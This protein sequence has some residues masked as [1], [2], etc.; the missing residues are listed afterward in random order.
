MVKINVSVSFNHCWFNIEDIV[1]DGA[2]TLLA[3][4]AGLC[5]IFI[6]VVFVLPVASSIP[7]WVIAESWGLHSAV[8]ALVCA[9]CDIL[10]PI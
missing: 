3:N 6:E 1:L 9:W 10:L 5:A 8:W 7:F 2:L 4:T